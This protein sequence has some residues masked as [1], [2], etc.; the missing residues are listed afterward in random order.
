MREIEQTLADMTLSAVASE[1]SEQPYENGAAEMR[2]LRARFV[3]A[4]GAHPELVH[5]AEYLFA[6]IYVRVRVVGHTLARHMH[7]P[8]EHLATEARHDSPQLTIEL[9]DE[10]ETSI[11]HPRELRDQIEGAPR[12]V[13]SPDARYVG[14]L[15]SGSLT[16]FDRVEKYM[17][18]WRASGERLWT[19]ERSKPLT[20]LLP[21][22]Y[23]DCGILMI[24]AGLVAL[25]AQGL[26]IGGPSGSGKTTTTL[27]CLSAGYDF[28][29]DDHCGLQAT[30][31]GIFVGHSFYSGARVAPKHL[32]RFPWLACHAIP[33]NDPKDDKLLIPMSQVFPS[34]LRRSANVRAIILPHLGDRDESSIRPASKGEAL[35]RLAPTSLIRQF[36]PGAG[37]FER[38]TELVNSVPSYWL[39]VGRDPAR[40]TSCLLE[41]V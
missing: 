19:G 20:Y 1:I 25:N 17:V 28:L 14:Y 2:A 33:S 21:I 22:W 15:M 26:I 6:G 7:Q 40:I 5:E 30:G 27:A 4:L 12:L 13:S 41:L 29:G 37:G 9:W 35:L 16:W 18:G 8:F 34:Q 11:S 3:Q 31:N 39:E 10:E 32:A 23:H 24:H 38:L 36:G